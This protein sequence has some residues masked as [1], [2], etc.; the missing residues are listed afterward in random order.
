MIDELW[1]EV[2]NSD[3]RALG[4]YLRHYSAR[5]NGATVKGN[6]NYERFCS[7]GETMVLLT[8]LCTALFV[9]NKQ[10]YRLDGQQGVNCAVFRNESAALSSSLILDAEA[11][12]YRRWPGSRFFTYVDASK[13]KSSN[14][15]YC[16]LKAGWRRAGI[17]KKK[18]LILL[19]KEIIL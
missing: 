4:I 1:I 9:W 17:S 15:G 3:H 7:P 18:H 5:K 16:F 12:A 14:P 10:Q 2:K 8:P 6:K 13:I 11:M 19:V